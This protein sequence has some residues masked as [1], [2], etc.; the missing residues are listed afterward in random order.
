[1][2]KGEALTQLEDALQDRLAQLRAFRFCGVQRVR[3]GKAFLL[4]ED[5]AGTRTTFALL[6]GETWGQAI[7]R[8]EDR[9]RAAARK[10]R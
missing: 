4:F 7:D 1:M 9:Y 10:S 6:P 5:S 3:K 2:G 8:F